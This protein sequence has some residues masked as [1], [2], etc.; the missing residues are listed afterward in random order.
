MLLPNWTLTPDEAA[1]VDSYRMGAAEPLL[2]FWKDVINNGLI[3][4]SPAELTAVRGS[5]ADFVI[6]CETLRGRDR[7]RRI[8]SE[9]GFIHASIIDE[10]WLHYRKF[11]TWILQGLILL[12]RYPNTCDKPNEERLEHDLHDLEYLILG[13]HAGNLAT[14]E[15]SNKLGRGSMSW[16]FKLL[17]PLGQLMM[18]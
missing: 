13:L 1:P 8:A 10:S 2:G 14:A 6:L 18:P 4:F 17:E 12:R 16:R 9:M 15:T 5:D 7:I 11:Q 3:G